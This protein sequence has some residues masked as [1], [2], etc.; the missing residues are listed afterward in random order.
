MGFVSI[1]ENNN[2][3][4]YSAYYYMIYYVIWDFSYKIKSC[5]NTAIFRLQLI[6]LDRKK[7]YPISK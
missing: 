2:I 5:S 1:N 6:S 3:I 7:K 4:R